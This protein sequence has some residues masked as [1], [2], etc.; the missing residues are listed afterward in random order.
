MTK[1]RICIKKNKLSEI[2]YQWKIKIKFKERKLSME[3]F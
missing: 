3:F 1:Q 2:S